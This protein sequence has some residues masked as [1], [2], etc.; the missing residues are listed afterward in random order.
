MNVPLHLWQ[1]CK[2]STKVHWKVDYLH[3]Y[4][5]YVYTNRNSNLFIPTVANC[6]GDVINIFIKIRRADMLLAPMKAD[7]AWKQQAWYIFADSQK[8]ISPLLISPSETSTIY[9]VFRDVERSTT[10][11][12][13]KFLYLWKEASCIV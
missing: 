1:L 5:W 2:H 8:N 9:L 12:Q 13:Q 11:V 3:V 10:E 7:S 6:C 4:L